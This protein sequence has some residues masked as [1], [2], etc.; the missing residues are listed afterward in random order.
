MGE[1]DIET[2]GNV[3]VAKYD[4]DDEAFNE[5]S[6]DALNFIT[7]LLVKETDK[8]MTATESLQ[9][10]WL[11]RQ[12]Q[13]EMRPPSGRSYRQGRVKWKSLK[14]SSAL[15]YRQWCTAMKKFQRRPTTMNS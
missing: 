10:Q 4:F 2:M 11:R 9:H 14:Y 5:I 6:E 15:I 3:T 13:G 8:R 12:Q 7:H 1:T